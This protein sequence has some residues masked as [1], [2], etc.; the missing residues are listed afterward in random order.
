[1]I[2]SLTLNPAIDV[3][4]STNR[5]VYDDR[6]FI[7]GEIE[8]AGGKG[9]NAAMVINAFGGDVRAVAGGVTNSRRGRDPAQYFRDR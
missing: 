1:M 7:T 2:L 9:I 5:I 3:A 4:L 6:S 8:T